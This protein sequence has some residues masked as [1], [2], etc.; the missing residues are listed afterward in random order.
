MPAFAVQHDEDPREKLLREVGDLANLE[1]FNN[2]V[3]VATYIRPEKTKS[4]IIV[5]HKTLD[6]DRYQSKI[7]LV[8]QIGPA[9]FNDPDGVWFKDARPQV[10]DWILFRNSDGWEMQ[11]RKTLCRML[12]DTSIRGRVQHPDDIY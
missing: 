2:Q 12:A 6:E 7:G 11:I 1:I 4:G 3:L 5:T 9:A 8:L 10:G